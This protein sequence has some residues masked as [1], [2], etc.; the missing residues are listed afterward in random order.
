MTVKGSNM[1]NGVSALSVPTAT[2]VSLDVNDW[3]ASDIATLK[4]AV[5]QI[6]STSYAVHKKDDKSFLVVVLNKE[7]IPALNTAYHDLLIRL[8]MAN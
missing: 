6:E 5:K 7:R 4:N 8:N 1:T 3:R 2:T